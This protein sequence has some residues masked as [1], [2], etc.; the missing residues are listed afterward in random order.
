M[1]KDNATKL[2]GLVRSL[3]LIPYLHSHSNATPMEI[4]RDLGYSHDEVMR[5]LTRLSMS[6]VGSGPDEL[7]DLVASWTGITVIDDQG[8]NKPLRLTQTEANALLLTLDS[9]ETMPGLVNQAAVTSAAAKLR[10]AVA[11]HGV[12]DA[13]SDAPQRENSARDVAVITEAIA[14]ARQ[15][16]IRYYSASSATTSR[17]TVSPVAVFHRNGASYLRAYEDGAQESKSFRLDRIISARLLDAAS[18]APHATNDVDPDDPF[19][20]ASRRRAELIVRRDA[21]WL[22]DYW[23][24]ELD[25]DAG[26]SEWLSAHMAYG[27]DDWLVRFCLSQ[28]DR[29]RLV[30]PVELS[31]QLV[32]RAQAGLD[33]L[34]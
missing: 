20:F 2:A 3:N 5:D 33:A 23:E 10:R 25:H 13:D 32:A 1:A 4:A 8:L 17:R 27:S 7:I 21:T 6:G 24:I 16:E 12:D 9:L 34:S 14:R 26:E 18:T 22:A 31:S 15:L 30:S 28:A 11:G 19:G 29:V